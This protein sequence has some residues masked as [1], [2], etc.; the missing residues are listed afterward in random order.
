[1]RV[2]IS[3]VGRLKSGPERELVDLYV[4][5]ASSAGRTIGVSSVAI[6]E[7]QESMAASLQ[8]R[9]EEEGSALLAGARGAPTLVALDEHG[10]NFSSREFAD[11]LRKCLDSG[12]DSLNFLIGGPDGLSQTVKES[13]RGGTI[14]FGRMS[15]PHRLARV[16]IA[17]QIYRAVTILINHPY[18]RD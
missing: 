13:A 2:L 15:W 1:M 8:T 14:A 7:H 12:T 17:E 9:L 16:M 6:V 3:A 11:F 10:R 5:R 4:Q 18:H